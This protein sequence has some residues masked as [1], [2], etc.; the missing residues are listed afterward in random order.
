MITL[1]NLTSN[2]TRSTITSLRHY[3]FHVGCSWASKPRLGSEEDFKQQ[4]AYSDKH[5]VA[6]WR[7]RMLGDRIKS[8]GDAGE[9]FWFI[10]PLKD[11]SG[12]ALG[13]ADGVGGW[14]SAKIDPS[15][16]SQTLMWAAAKKAGN[17]LAAQAAPVDLIDAGHKGVLDM[18]DVKAGSSTACVVTLDA[19]SG[20][21][22]GANL[23]DSTFVL[24]RDADVVES[25]KQQTHFFNCPFQLA[26]LRKGI[27]KNHITDYAHSAD[28]FETP[29]QAGDC[30]VLFV[31]VE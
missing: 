20:L 22:K 8:V 27:D 21:L 15:K 29:L 12:L 24:I 19:Q 7:S 10:E 13:I 25:T 5:E 3:T 18:E 9:D 28:V 23:G 26:K 11:D 31:G 1:R 16:F 4:S 17:L 2:S 30:V 6:Q 14:F